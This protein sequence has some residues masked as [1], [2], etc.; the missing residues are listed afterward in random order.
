MIE[1]LGGRLNLNAIGSTSLPYTGGGLS[2]QNA[3]WSKDTTE[4][5]AQYGATP[6]VLPENVFR[7]LGWGPADATLPITLLGGNVS[8]ANQTTISGIFDGILNQRY[9][10]G[11]RALATAEVP[12]RDDREIYDA[13]RF[14][15][16]LR[17]QRAAD[18]MGYSDDV[19]GRGGIAMG[20]DGNLV[21]ADSGILISVDDTTTTSIVEPTIDEAINTAYESDPTGAIG[22]DSP[23]TF[24]EF[25]GLL[26][27]FDFDTELLPNRLTA[28]FSDIGYADANFAQ[29]LARSLTPHSRSDDSPTSFGESS[30]AVLSLIELLQTVAGNTYSQAE[31]DRLLPPE[32]RLANKL[33]INRPFGN[34]SDDNGN[35]VID[36]PLETNR[37]DADGI[38]NDGDSAMDETD[39]SEKT[40]G[41][42]WSAY[43]L[44]SSGYRVRDG[45]TILPAEYRDV[46][47]NYVFD[48]P[49]QSNLSGSFVPT[50][51]HGRQLLARHLY[52]LM[53]LLTR[54]LSTAGSAA[55][56]IPVDPKTDA[57]FT[58]QHPQLYRARR[59]AQWAINVVDYRDPDSIMTPF[60]YDPDPFTNGVGAAAPYGWDV[61]GNIATTESISVAFSATGAATTITRPVVWGVE[62]PDLMFSESLA[63][64]DVRVRDINRDDG[65]SD[66][67][68]GGDVDTDQVRMPQGSL[69]LELYCPRPLINNDQTTKSRVPREL[70]DMA[71]PANG[72][73]ELDL[74]RQ[75]PIDIAEASTTNRTGVPVWRIAI[76]QRGLRGASRQ[77]A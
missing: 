9:Q 66:D 1:D 11:Q 40:Q 4:Y 27:Q 18:S 58:G 64:H 48:S 12:G 70:Y 37:S 34:L 62:E 54:D 25:E 75:A 55:P 22:A 36:E 60:E 2:T 15:Y 42:L 76:T 21:V 71:T 10:F 69:F 46:H 61:D 17:F 51:D 13:I 49:A 44:P 72:I 24:T 50:G 73:A 32:L 67:I 14:G 43:A 45:I 3:L 29:Q 16:R 26:R 68:G 19:F 56:E 23:F 30:S 31:L 8:A 57:L 74:D 65:G 53:M 5:N 52:V 38:D 47:P 7:G 33:D 28:S 63:L 35:F 20:R 6:A 39:G 41:E 77:P 59:I